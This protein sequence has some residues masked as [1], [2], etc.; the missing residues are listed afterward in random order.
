MQTHEE[1]RFNNYTRRS[2]PS[3]HCTVI[4]IDEIRMGN[5]IRI[6]ISAVEDNKL[7]EAFDR[8]RAAALC[9][10]RNQRMI[11]HSAGVEWSG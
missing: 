7:A 3:F 5:D 10:F 6:G 11:P 4:V 2:M 1:A 8:A 9:N